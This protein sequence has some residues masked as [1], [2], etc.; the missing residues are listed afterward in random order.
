M[1]FLEKI[2]PKKGTAESVILIDI[3]ADHL[4][5]AYGR[6]QEKE[7][8]KLLYAR[9]LPIEI[10]KDEAQERAMLRTLTILGNDLIR[11]GAP[12]LARTTGTGSADM[13]LVSIDAP[14]QETTVRTEHLE[15]KKDFIFTKNLIAEKLKEANVLPPEKFLAD[16]SIIGT[17][18]NG[19][20]TTNPY[21]KTA[22]RAALVI[23]TSLIERTVAHAI[24]ATLKEMY[25]TKNILPIAG[26]SL[27]FQALCDMFPHEQG[28]LII[29]MTSKTL[30]SLALVRKGILTVMHQKTTT[31]DAIGWTDTITQ[32]LS[33][34]AKSYPLPRTIFLL[35][36]E[37]DLV[38][39]R[40]KL[41][42]NKIT[43]LWLSAHP[44]T[45]I[46]IEK[47]LMTTFIQSVT[48]HMPDL[49]LLLMMEYYQNKHFISH[50][51]H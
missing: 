34:I 39:L 11:E 29:D 2:F 35:A 1:G 5:G 10:R 37:S 18:L 43:Q 45:I 30:V 16:E 21:G 49:S 32:T 8:P 50:H 14:W 25:H 48:T 33:E 51:S 15:Q 27:R 17:I 28:A 19:Y 26:N 38:S 4:S 7:L 9:T 47:T 23:L 44:P 20:E 22:R 31:A 36:P 24:I 42:E 40:E 13:I 3:G 41:G 6:F 12:I 46:S